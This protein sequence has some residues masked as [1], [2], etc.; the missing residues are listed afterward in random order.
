MQVKWRRKCKFFNVKT[1]VIE[2]IKRKMMYFLAN[3]AIAAV[4]G[5]ATQSFA[6]HSDGDVPLLDAS[7]NPVA[8]GVPY[9]PKQTCGATGCHDYESA[10]TTATKTQFNRLGAKVSYDTPYPQHGVS[11]GYHFQQGRNIDW[12]D[13]Q[14]T[15]YGQYD[16]TSSA[17]MFGKY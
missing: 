4:V 10:W 14:K 7:G 13:T 16:F 15:A 1:T 2:M 11:A 9:S 8:A 6:A 3:A 5:F 12:D 17:G